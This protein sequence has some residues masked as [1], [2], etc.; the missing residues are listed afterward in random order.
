MPPPLQLHADVKRAPQ[1]A[2]DQSDAEGRELTKGDWTHSHL[3]GRQPRHGLLAFSALFGVTALSCDPEPQEDE[4]NQD[5]H[6]LE[7]NIHLR[8]RQ[9]MKPKDPMDP[10]DVEA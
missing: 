10:D 1:R 4:S 7:K 2:L 9:V 3:P 8:V 5:K 6:G